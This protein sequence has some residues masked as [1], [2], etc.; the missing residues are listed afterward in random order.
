MTTADIKRED[1]KRARAR[2]AQFHLLLSRR[3]HFQLLG[4]DRGADDE[5]ITTAFKTMAKRW[6]ADAF[7]NVELGPDAEKADEIFKRLNEAYETLTD[8]HRR[9]EYLVFLDRSAKG[10]ATDV[11]GVLRAEAMVDEALLDM[12][13]RQWTVAE[14][15]LNE[16]RSL[17]P[18]DPLYD[19]HYA[20]ARYNLAKDDA[21][22]VKMAIDL[23]KGA[24]KR[25]RQ[26]AARLPVPRPDSLQPKRVPRSQEVV[27]DLFAV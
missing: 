6:H 14:E 13:R 19:V 22:G 9:E 20:W 4:I 1:S 27:E 15:K 3:N 10:L 23:L 12:K 21:D 17:N 2:V 26:L 7:A 8:P 25:Q 16:A 11:H 5:T 24:T 18:D